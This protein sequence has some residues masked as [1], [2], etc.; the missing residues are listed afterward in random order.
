MHFNE[1]ASVSNSIVETIEMN[2]TTDHDQFQYWLADMD[3]AL[4]RFVDRAPENAKARLDFSN[5]SLEALEEL[6][7][8]RYPNPA[9]ARDRSEAAFVD[10]AARYIG[11]VFRLASGSRW[12][13]DFSDPKKVYYG[14]PTLKGGTLQAALCPI[15]LVVATTDR[16]TGGYLASIMRNVKK[17][18]P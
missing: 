13:I 12:S 14:R 6:I 7:L 15:S 1:L 11:E 2:A 16:R 17:P 18:C 8:D 10:G 4:A 5:E 9:A 3:D